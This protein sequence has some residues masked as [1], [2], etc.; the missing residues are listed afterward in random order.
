VLALLTTCMRQHG[1]NVPPPSA[2]GKL[3]TK[4]VDTKSPQFKKVVKD[5]L[6]ALSKAGSPQTG[7][8][9]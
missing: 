7:S 9:G 1:V 2:T 6:L 5:C 8:A 4:G 3:D